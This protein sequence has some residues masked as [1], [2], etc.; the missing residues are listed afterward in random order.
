MM[1]ARRTTVTLEDDVV[2]RLT[3]LMRRTGRPLKDVLNDAVRRGLDR[4]S[5]PPTPFRVETRDLGTQ[6][7]IELDDIS[8]LL[9]QIEGPAFR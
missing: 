1:M 5:S 2:E 8:Q 3:A 6:P 4:P 9:E 7:G